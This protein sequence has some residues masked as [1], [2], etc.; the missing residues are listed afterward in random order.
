M[1]MAEKKVLTNPNLLNIILSF[2]GV[3]IKRKCNV[4]GMVIKYQILNLEIE[5]NHKCYINLET[6]EKKYFCDEECLNMYKQRYNNE[7]FCT[8]FF[9]I[10]VIIGLLMC[11]IV[12]LFESKQTPA[13]NINLSV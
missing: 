2:T 11:L 10:L 13:I 1:Y 5:F 3:E 9:L 6:C 7:R 4:C 8:F 12:V